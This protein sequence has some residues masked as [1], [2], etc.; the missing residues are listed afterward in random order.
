LAVEAEPRDASTEHHR[1]DPD[2]D[3]VSEA[4]PEHAPDPSL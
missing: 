2:V 1:N 4:R 3:P